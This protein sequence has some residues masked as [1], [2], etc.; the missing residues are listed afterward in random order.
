MTI[1]TFPSPQVLG[2]WGDIVAS[3]YF[4]FGVDCETPNKH[5]EGLFEILNKVAHIARIICTCLVALFI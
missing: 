2:Y 1:F 3:P 4:S 5:A